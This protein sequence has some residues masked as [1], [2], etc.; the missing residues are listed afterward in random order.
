MASKI[1]YSDNGTKVE[2]VEAF[3]KVMKVVEHCFNNPP[4]EFRV[5]KR[6]VTHKLVADILF[7]V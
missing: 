6:C 7:F 3:V 5:Q 1:G 2:V 4:L